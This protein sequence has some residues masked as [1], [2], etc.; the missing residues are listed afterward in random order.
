MAWY[1]ADGNTSTE[2]VYSALEPEDV[3]FAGGMD[4]KYTGSFVPEITW[5]GFTLNAMFAY[6][7]GHYMRANALLGRLAVRSLVMVMELG[8]LF[9]LLE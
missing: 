5:K 4:P 3:V 2:G 8:F 9:K 6:Y 7:G 1:K